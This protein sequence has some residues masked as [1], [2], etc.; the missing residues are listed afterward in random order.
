M[1]ILHV[2]IPLCIFLGGLRL[3]EQIPQLKE[4]PLKQMNEKTVTLL[5]ELVQTK[6]FRIIRL[7]IN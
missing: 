4:D 3:L 6:Y 5:E 1:N 7:N 2:I